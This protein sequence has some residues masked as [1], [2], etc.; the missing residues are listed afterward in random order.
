M[1]HV[2]CHII[3]INNADVLVTETLEICPTHPCAE[4]LPM[5]TYVE[6]L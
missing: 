3:G 6:V 4:A 1:Q 5:L 2:S